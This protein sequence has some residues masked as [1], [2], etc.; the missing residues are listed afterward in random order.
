MGWIPKKF[1]FVAK[2]KATSLKFVSK[3]PHPPFGPA[4]ADVSVVKTR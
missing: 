1:D 3:T 4:I 2:T